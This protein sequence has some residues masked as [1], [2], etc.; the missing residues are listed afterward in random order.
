[1]TALAI[2]A[3]MPIFNPP[4]PSHFSQPPAPPFPS[5]FKQ[6]LVEFAVREGRVD[7][8]R[9][10]I[11]AGAKLDRLGFNGL[12]ALQLAA[13]RNDAPMVR[14]SYQHCSINFHTNLQSV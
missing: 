12:T 8:M 1:M 10:L 3:H 6:E 14:K 7:V 9:A 4:L 2:A 13:Y 5:V 11:T